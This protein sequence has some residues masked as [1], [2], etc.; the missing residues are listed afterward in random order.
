MSAQEK[1]FVVVDPSDDVHL[2]L[3][4]ALITSQLRAVSPQLHVFVAVDTQSVDTRV[5][6]ENLFRDQD[7][8]QEQIRKPMEEKGLEGKIEISWSSD[9]QD[10]IMLSARRFCADLILLPVRVKPNTSRFSF[11][12]SKWGLLR[13]ADCPVLLAR[14]GAK[15][16][17]KTV[18]AAVN[19]QATREFQRELNSAILERS[20]WLAEIYGADFHVVNGYLDS[21]HYPDRGRLANE[22]GLPADKIHVTQ[23]YTDEVV[24][25][26]AADIGA[27]LVV[28]GTLGQTGKSRTRRGNTAERV[29]SALN[30]DVMVVNN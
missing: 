14:P 18:L 8:F 30:C 4:R 13:N 5:I 12:E 19:F 25:A 26:V 17:R 2:A 29:I 3:E 11:S 10:A 27:D 15:E 21:M 6:N 20:K 16:Q 24:S 22:T 9:W 28:I 23:G 7:W 1:L